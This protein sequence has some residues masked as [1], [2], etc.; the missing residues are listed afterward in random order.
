M[1]LSLF[2]FSGLP[3]SHRLFVTYLLLLS[4]RLSA[5]QWADYIEQA[6]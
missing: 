1:L 6:G 2:V 3:W 5:G 4:V